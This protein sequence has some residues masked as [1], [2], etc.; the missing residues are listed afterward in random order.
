MPSVFHRCGRSG[1]SHHRRCASKSRRGPNL[2]RAKAS[3]GEVGA[4]ERHFGIPLARPFRYII[5]WKWQQ[6]SR[7]RPQRQ[8]K[9]RKWADEY[10]NTVYSRVRVCSR[11]CSAAASPKTIAIFIF[12][13]STG[14]VAGSDSK[15]LILKKMRRWKESKTKRNKRLIGLKQTFNQKRL[16][17][18]DASRSRWWSENPHSEWKCCCCPATLQTLW[19]FIMFCGEPLIPQLN[20]GKLCVDFLLMAKG[21]SQLIWLDHWLV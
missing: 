1:R 2:A 19:V 12:F 3:T 21:E 9:K 4:A 10:V 14:T 8:Q 18:H 15:P 17:R 13:S 6:E 11:S 20:V 16:C 5:T 7:S